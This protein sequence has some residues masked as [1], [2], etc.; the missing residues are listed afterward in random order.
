[1]KIQNYPSRIVIE[2]TPE[3]NLSC[4][5]CPRKYVGRQNG[6]ISKKLWFKLIRDVAKSSP[7]SVII[8]FWRGE[9]LLHPDFCDLIELALEKSLRVHISTNGTLLDAKNLSLLAKCDFVTFSIHTVSGYEAAKNFLG[10]RRGKRPITQ[11][12][13]V[14]D[15]SSVKKISSSI[16]DSPYLQGFDSVRVYAEHTKGGVF[17][18]SGKKFGFK[19]IFC[20]KLQDTLVIAHDGTISRCCYIWET[21]RNIDVNDMSIRKA[22]DSQCLR[23]IRENYPDLKCERCDQWA[24]NTCGELW[25]NKNG[26]IKHNNFSP[27]D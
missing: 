2:L 7:Q 9:S 12:S 6:Y 20:P 1:M 19:R 11:I 23:K 3:C 25:Q 13:F 16:I 15:E 26:R 24:G 10:L 21:E 14:D 18:S 4:R 5:M 8:P 22:W 27:K 17:G